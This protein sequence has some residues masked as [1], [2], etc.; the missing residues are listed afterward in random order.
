MCLA[1]QFRRCRSTVS[2]LVVIALICK[3]RTPTLNELS[4]ITDTIGLLLSRFSPDPARSWPWL[5]SAWPASLICMLVCVESL[6]GHQYIS[7]ICGE[8]LASFLSQGFQYLEWLWGISLPALSWSVVFCGWL[9][10]S[11]SLLCSG[12]WRSEGSHVLAW[13]LN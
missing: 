10:S 2:H 13:L 5:Y 1:A 4:D 8:R 3:I 12:I 9:C 11:L 7:I 6:A